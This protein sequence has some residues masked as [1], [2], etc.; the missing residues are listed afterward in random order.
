MLE[1]VKSFRKRALKFEK[2]AKWNLEQGDYDLAVLHVEQAAQLMLKA[3]LLELIGD[4]PKTH[5]LVQLV[6]LL[7]EVSKKEE[8]AKFLAKNKI[9]LARLTDAYL[10]SR[11][12]T[13]EFY[14][15]EAEEALS[16]LDELKK[17][18]GEEND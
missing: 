14:R 17:V 10:F 18:L 1:L 13:R 5:N 3:K 6:K 11:Y 16:L 4:F 15:E 2:N 12:F 8:V 7:Y 9:R